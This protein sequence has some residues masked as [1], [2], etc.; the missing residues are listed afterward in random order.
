MTIDKDKKKKT[1][2]PN[3]K[4]YR[5]GKSDDEFIIFNLSEA[6]GTEVRIIF[7]VLLFSRYSIII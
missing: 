6:V 5:K 4:Y 2:C 3:A 7:L 1:Y